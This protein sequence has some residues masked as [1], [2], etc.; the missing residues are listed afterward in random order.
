MKDHVQLNKPT[1]SACAET[2]LSLHLLDCWTLSCVR[3]GTGGG[4]DPERWAAEGNYNWHYTLSPSEWFCIKMCSNE[5]H[6][7][8]PLIV[9]GKVATSINVS[10]IFWNQSLP[11]F[12]FFLR[13][14]LLLFFQETIF[15][16]FLLLLTDQVKYALKH[17]VFGPQLLLLYPI[18]S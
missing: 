12:V 5:S 14:F 1:W 9:R 3:T 4:W 13:P 10:L 11:S 8:V 17:A 7:H 18:I 6:F 15:L 2:A 16:C